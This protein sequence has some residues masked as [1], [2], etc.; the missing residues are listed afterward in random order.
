MT[1]ILI[2]VYL[3]IVAYLSYLGFKKTSGTSDYLLAGRDIHPYVMALSYG[4][5]FISTSAIIGFGGAASIFGMSMLWLTALNISV[6]V[7][8]AFVFFGKRTR[9]MGYHLHAHTFPEFLAK[10]FKSPFI[11]KFTGAIIFI[12]MPLY[13]AVVLMG[14]A[15]FIEKQWSVNYGTSLFF[16]TLVIAV[17]VIIGGLKGVMYSDAFQGTI[18][19]IGMLILI[20]VTYNILGG[21]TEAH[22]SLTNMSVGPLAAKGHMGW[23]S[24]PQFKSEFWWIVVSTIILGVGIGV[25]AQPQL[26]VR[27]MTVK[28]DRELNRAILVGGLFI[29]IMTGVSFVAGSLSNVYFAKNIDNLEY[30]KISGTL[31]DVC[32]GKKI[33]LVTEKNIVKI[34]ESFPK[35]QIGKKI[36]IHN[37]IDHQISK[38]GTISI[39]AVGGSVASVIPLYIKNAM[40]SWFG[41]LFM[42]TLIAAAMSTLSSQF[43]TMGTSIGR[44]IYEQLFTNKKETEERSVL[45][46]KFGIGFTI[47]ISGIIAYVLPTVFSKGSAIIARGTAIFF[48]ICAGSFLPAYI[49]ALYFKKITK[50]GAIAGIIGGFTA[51]SFW[52][53]FVHTKESEIFGLAKLITG[54]D[55]LFG[56]PWNVIDPLIIGLPTSIILTIIISKF[57]KKIDGSHINLCFK[58]IEK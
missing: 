1:L 19:F 32:K 52:I 43:H 44:D 16:F 46:S 41:I 35:A 54:N 42:L 31:K 3:S 23:T 17:Y 4:A 58:N 50:E 30:C 49:G 14:A 18:M 51:S 6:G 21:V 55:S 36:D 29:M 5:T 9:K 34:K 53:I 12:F 28:S 57:T 27:F 24:M 40:P 26:I 39:K 48:G 45:I 37:G 7:F 25:L 47:I 10:R 8:I 56:S 20:I 38:K 15:K 22:Q 13:S 11:Q 33:V 2:I